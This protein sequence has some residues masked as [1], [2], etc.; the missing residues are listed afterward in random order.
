MEREDENK[1][2]GVHFLRFQLPVDSIDGLKKG[3][4]LAVGV[5]HSAYSHRVDEVSAEIRVAL[6]RDLD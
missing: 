6:V 4:P 1:T 3:Q 5:D 2:S